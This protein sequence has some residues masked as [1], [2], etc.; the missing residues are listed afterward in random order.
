MQE[1]CVFISG[2]LGH[3]NNMSQLWS[4]KDDDRVVGEVAQG[5]G[6]TNVFDEAMRTKVNN[7][8]MINNEEMQKWYERYEEKRAE[9][10]EAR[11]T[12]RRTNNSVPSA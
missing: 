5:N 8:C 12:W 1:S 6:V 11:E 9:Q 3:K 2:Y 10:I 7:Y 4:T